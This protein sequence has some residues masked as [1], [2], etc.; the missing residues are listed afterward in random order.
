MGLALLELN[1]N[2]QSTLQNGTKKNRKISIPARS[3]ME[4]QPI[5]S[6]SIYERLAANRK[7]TICEVLGSR[8]V[9]EDIF[10]AGMCFFEQ[11]MNAIQLT[12]LSSY[13]RD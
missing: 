3:Q 12:P 13:V 8:S 10:S 7:K 5:C 9:T 11:T 6:T 4:V 2:S 1:Q